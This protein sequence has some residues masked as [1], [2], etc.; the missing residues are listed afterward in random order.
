MKT[1]FKN[2]LVLA[3]MLGT[4]TSY[5]NATLEVLPT[6][7]SVKKGNSISVTDA[8]GKIV[9]SGLI[10]FNGNISHLYDFS[11]LKDGTYI[12]EVNKDFEIEI[13][14][15]EVKNNTVSFIN[16]RSEKIFKPVFRLENDKLLIS[17]MALDYPKMEV[18]LYYGNELIHAETVK[19]GE[20]LNRVYQLDD[21]IKGEYTAVV[22]SN[23]RVFAKNFRI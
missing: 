18:E 13:S 5:A 8:S 2:M 21:T 3:V 7:N 20:I 11:Q 19:G 16:K 14:T 6:F 1:L 23:G 12:I 15:V 10:N 9:F 22:K 17:K 4:C